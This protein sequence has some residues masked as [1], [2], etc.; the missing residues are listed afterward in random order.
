[1]FVPMQGA[2]AVKRIEVVGKESLN[3]ESV[4]KVYRPGRAYKPLGLLQRR[5]GPSTEIFA[6]SGLPLVRYNVCTNARCIWKGSYGEAEHKNVNP[7]LIGA[8]S[9]QIWTG[10]QTTWSPAAPSIEICAKSGQ[11][12]A[13]YNVCTNARCIWKGSYWGIVNW[14]T[15]NC[16]ASRPNPFLMIHSVPAYYDGVS[17]ICY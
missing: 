6:N 9:V 2:Y 13:R 3:P 5:I 11:S 7:E 16:H 8:K 15:R 10:L 17:S 1:M 4:Q 14:S 12:L